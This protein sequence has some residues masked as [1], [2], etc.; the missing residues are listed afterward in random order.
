MQR[1]EIENMGKIGNI[2][3]ITNDIN[4]KVYIGQTIR[5]LHE[6]MLQHTEVN[7]IT[8]NQAIKYA[9]KKYGKEHFSISL[10]ER[11]P[12]ELLNEREMFWISYFNSY[13]N[14]YN[15][16]KGGDSHEH[17]LALNDYQIKELCSL[18]EQGVSKEE[19]SGKYQLCIATIN[20]YLQ[21]NNLQTN[22]Q[23]LI[24][25]I[26]KKDFISY[27]K[28]GIHTYKDI[29]DKFQICRSS[30]FNL[31]RKW[32]LENL[33]S[34]IVKT[35]RAS[36]AIENHDYICSLYIKGYNIKD[37]CSIVH[38]SK[39]YISNE[40]NKQGIIIKHSKRTKI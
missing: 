13:Y 38:C 18:Y 7:K 21:D 5:T 28:E 24:N 4:L 22:T 8:C 40:L 1:I 3:I 27:I 23:K 39:K 26:D 6:R 25:T 30:I 32:N 17:L 14:G 31:I 36:K 29:Q 16:T 2:Y 10:V 20:K 12:V 34:Y 15:N 19:L 11:C 35:K 33:K 37:V 9:I